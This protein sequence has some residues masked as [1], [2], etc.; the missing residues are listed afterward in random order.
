MN[1]LETENEII[2]Y[3]NWLSTKPYPFLKCLMTTFNLHLKM[4]TNRYPNL[5]LRMDLLNEEIQKKN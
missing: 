4:E 2:A 1:P 5:S 3:K